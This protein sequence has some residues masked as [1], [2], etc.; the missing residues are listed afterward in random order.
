MQET[1]QPHKERIV[2]LGGGVAAM[3]A[4]YELTD[5]PG[6]QNKYTIDVCQLGW[7]LGDKGA[8]GRNK[9]K[10]ERIEEHG[11]HIW[12]GIYQNAFNL[13]RR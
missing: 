5:Q 12:F 9:D 1:A 11:L 2:I 4:A 13:I 10:H 3:T 8:S 7:R 6:W